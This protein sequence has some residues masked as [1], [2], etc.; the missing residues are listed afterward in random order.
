MKEIW[1]G[2]GVDADRWNP[3][4]CEIKEDVQGTS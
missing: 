4:L 3:R 1:N 2:M